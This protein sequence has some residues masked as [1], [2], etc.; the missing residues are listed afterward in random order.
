M[1]RRDRRANT[2]LWPAVA[3]HLEAFPVDDGWAG[4]VVLLLADPHLLEGGQGSQDGSTDPYGV[5]ALW[6][7]NDLDLHGGWGKGGYL[8][9]HPVSDTWVHGGASGQDSVGV[10]I[11]TDVNI[12]LH[13]GVVGGLVDTGRFHTQEGWLE[14]GLGATEPLVSDGDDLTVGKLVGLLEG[15]GGGGG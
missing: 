1:T 12:A 14:Q 11:L 3:R 15:R 8:L 5:F 2:W 4:L 6:G 13:D 10:Q 9:L 7:S